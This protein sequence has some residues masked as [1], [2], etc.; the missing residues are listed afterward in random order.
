MSETNQTSGSGLNDTVAMSQINRTLKESETNV[1][2]TTESINDD[3]EIV[4]ECLIGL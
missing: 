3:G 1:T 4:G 2:S